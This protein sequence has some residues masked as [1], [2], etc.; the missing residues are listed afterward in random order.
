METCLRYPVITWSQGEVAA[1]QGITPTNLQCLLTHWSPGTT[2]EL[3]GYRQGSST[4]CSSGS[5]LR[6]VL[7]GLVQTLVSIDL[8]L[9]ELQATTHLPVIGA[10][11]PKAY[12]AWPLCFQPVS[13]GEA[14]KEGSGLIHPSLPSLALFSFLSS[15][16]SLLFNSIYS[17]TCLF[18]F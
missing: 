7:M 10:R 2:V 16:M 17:K 14:A 6:V 1:R 4:G 18:P 5:M 3:V 11:I 13:L 8:F 12:Q 9:Q 15:V